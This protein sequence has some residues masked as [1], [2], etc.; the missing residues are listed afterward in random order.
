MRLDGPEGK[1]RKGGCITEMEVMAMMMN[2]NKEGERLEEALELL[3]LT[4]KNL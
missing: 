2:G 1:C 3:Q 4:P